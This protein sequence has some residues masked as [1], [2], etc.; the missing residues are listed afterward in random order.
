MNPGG[1]PAIPLPPTGGG[2]A[3]ANPLPSTGGG[4]N[5]R[6]SAATKK[7]A[8]GNLVSSPGW[9]PHPLGHGRRTTTTR[10]SAAKR[11]VGNAPSPRVQE[12]VGGIQ[13]KGKSQEQEP[14]EPEPRATAR[15]QE[16]RLR[17]RISKGGA[18]EAGT[19]SNFLILFYQQPIRY[20]GI[21][22]SQNSQSKM[23]RVSNNSWNGWR[24]ND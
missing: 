1:T 15:E 16:S 11:E 19:P 3:A 13:A 9:K 18:N 12:L 24:R 5:H 22:Q 21:R 7:A 23:F 10:R 17:P 6:E 2:R 4:R 14:N 20:P 8:G